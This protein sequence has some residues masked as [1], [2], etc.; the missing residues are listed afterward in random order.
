MG[1]SHGGGRGDVDVGSCCCF[2]VLAEAKA[3]EELQAVIAANG[4]SLA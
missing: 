2:L 1:S 3:I 4:I